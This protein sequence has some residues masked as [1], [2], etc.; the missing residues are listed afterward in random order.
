MVVLLSNCSLENP[1]FLRK[2][3]PLLESAVDNHQQLQEDVGFDFCSTTWVIPQDHPFL[4]YTTRGANAKE[5]VTQILVETS[6]DTLGW[7]LSP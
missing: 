2:F 5:E 4:I 3:W 1:E 7:V 6:A